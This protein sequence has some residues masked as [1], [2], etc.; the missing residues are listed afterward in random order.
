MQNVLYILLSIIVCLVI[1]VVVG[2][3]FNGDWTPYITLT[4]FAGIIIGLLLRIQNMI[5][6]K[7]E[8]K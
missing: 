2:A 6:Q 7:M 4:I 1:F 3:V 8:N 5:A